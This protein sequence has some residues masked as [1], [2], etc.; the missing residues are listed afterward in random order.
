VGAGHLLGS[1]KIIAESCCS[2]HTSPPSKTAASPSVPST[3]SYW[4]WSFTDCTTSETKGRP[5][6]RLA[7]KTV[8]FGFISI[9]L[10]AGCPTRKWRFA[11]TATMEGMVLCPSRDGMTKGLPS[12]TAATQ[13]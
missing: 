5:T 11:S 9:W 3:I 7:P 8:C 10:F 2:D 1:T 12:F 6:S 4:K 13:E